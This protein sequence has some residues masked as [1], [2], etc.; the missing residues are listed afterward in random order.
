MTNTAYSFKNNIGIGRL[1]D[2]TTFLFDPSHYSRIKDQNWY[3]CYNDPA[4][5]RW[6]YIVDRA[7][8]KMHEYLTDCPSGMEVDHIN[9]NT[10]DNRDCN[11]RICTHQQNQCNQ[12]LQR[13]NTSGVTGVSFYS[14]RNK[15]RARI[16]VGQHDI[17][18]G[19]YKSFCEAIQ[20]R[21]IGMECM[22]GEYGVYNPVPPAPEW[23]RKKVY[24]ICKRFADLAVGGAF[25]HT[26]ENLITESA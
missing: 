4:K 3:R 19:Y 26:R 12:P 1:S 23:I 13:N 16:K 10:L 15:Y 21:N 11:L 2:G 25:F 9:K 17:H 20:A 18:L 22:F 7:G 8:H 14:P 6:C 5:K 24:G